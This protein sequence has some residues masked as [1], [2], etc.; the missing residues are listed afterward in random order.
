MKQGGMLRPELMR[1]SRG[2][3]CRG[4]NSLSSVLPSLSC[5]LVLGSLSLED[6][7]LM[8]WGAARIFC[9]GGWRSRVRVGKACEHL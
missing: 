6:T 1:C 7:E 4:S 8:W 3:C 2:A 5:A 9:G